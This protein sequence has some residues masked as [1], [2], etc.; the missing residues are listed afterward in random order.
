M[1][2]HAISDSSTKPIVMCFSGLDPTGGA[3]IQ[4]DIE[5]LFSAGCHC[6]PIVTALTAQ[7]TQNVKNIRISDATFLIEQARAILEDA[8]VAVFKIGLL[9]SV[10][11][12]EVIHTILS[13][14]PNIPVIFDPIICAGGGYELSSKEMIAAM[15]SMLLPMTTLLT[16]N[17]EEVRLLAPDADNVNA[18]A[19]AL[20]DTGCKH[21]LV[22]GTHTASEQVVNHLYTKHRK[23]ES[24][25]WP[26]LK[27]QYHG[28]GCTLA[29]C[30]AAYLAHGLDMIEAVQEAQ[31]FTWHALDH[32]QRLGLGQLIPNRSYWNSNSK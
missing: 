12:V 1:N 11:I 25:N 7:D 14:Y 23:T 20:L 21:V 5:T 3:G 16:P 24:Y 27:H 9:G 32:G 15:Q 22:T 17:T 10:A 29:A 4:A 8:P 19:H 13:D 2:Q 18:C 26:R 28:S 30:L 6:S 31:Q